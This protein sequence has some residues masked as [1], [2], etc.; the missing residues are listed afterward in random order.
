MAMKINP[1]D[2]SSCGAC[3]A[4]CPT[5]SISAGPTSYVINAATCT[6]CD[7]DPKCAATC[8]MEAITKA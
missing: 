2:C 5:N 4:E 6:E 7:G 3:E 1:D 8:P